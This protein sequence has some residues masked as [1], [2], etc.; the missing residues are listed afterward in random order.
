MGAWSYKSRARRQSPLH[1]DAARPGGGASPAPSYI[2]RSCPTWQLGLRHL[3]APR[4]TLPETEDPT[5]AAIDLVDTQ[6]SDRGSPESSGRSFLA[7][8][9][10]A[11]E[12]LTASRFGEYPSHEQR[13]QTYGW[14]RLLVAA[15]VIGRSDRWKRRL[16]GLAGELQDRLAEA[17]D[18]PVSQPSLAWTQHLEPP[19]RLRGLSRALRR[20]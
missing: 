18:E 7:L 17:E 19:V 14:E 5:S 15:A 13:E 11:E 1:A 2:G 9:H 4:P 8:L 12:N 16:A 10:C 6:Y 3:A 20:K